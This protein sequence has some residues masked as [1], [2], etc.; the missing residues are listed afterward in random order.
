MVT[1]ADLVRLSFSPDLTLGGVAY[2]CRSLP[3]TY[4]R[5]GGSD[6]Q[7]MRR[8]VAG[9]AVELA[10][11]RRLAAQDV[12]YDTLGATPFT[13]PDQYDVALGGRR[14]DLKSFLIYQKPTIHRLK[15]NPAELL[16]AEALVPSEQAA[17]DA[18]RP[19]DLFIFAFV[20]ALITPR[21]ED[22]QRAL[23]AEQPVFLLH[24][25]PEAWRRPPA[26]VSLGRLALKAEG[27]QAL[28]LELGGQG[29][30]R[31]FRTQDVPLSP[32]VRAT[33]GDDFYALAY[34]RAPAL[35]DGRVGV[36]SPRL[37]STYIIQ[38]GD[39][40]NI[41]VY[42]MEIFL[43]GYMTCAEFRRKARHL[44]AGSQVWQYPRT[45]VKNLALPVAE[46]HPMEELFEAAKAW[47]G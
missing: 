20:T 45:R 33:V 38:P 37:D 23:S 1:E 35:P 17:S 14:C 39:W 19:Q 15:A 5:M 34:L 28:T 26:W 3:H 41:W 9:K 47:G 13:D 42:G 10:F 25:L 8:I 40:G 18:L 4:D 31:A 24:P 29:E 16:Q 7:R 6:F 36:Y 46:L 32:G 44:P 11:R 21:G 22:L 27:T 30:D 43:C 2:A 12:P